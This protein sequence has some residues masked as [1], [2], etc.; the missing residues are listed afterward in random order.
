[1]VAE[2]Y[3]KTKIRELFRVKRW[4]IGVA[5]L[6]MMNEELVVEALGLTITFNN[7]CKIKCLGLRWE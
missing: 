6:S 7:V 3:V 2:G 5:V 1:M 4:A